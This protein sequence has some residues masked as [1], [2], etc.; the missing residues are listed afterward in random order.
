MSPEA[1]K[2][3]PH[4]EWVTDGIRRSAS[5]SAKRPAWTGTVA[6]LGA[7]VRSAE[8]LIDER[9]T[10]AL[11]AYDAETEE[12]VQKSLVDT[13]NPES[14]EKSARSMRAEHRIRIDEG[15]NARA[16]VS[17]RGLQKLEGTP[18]EVLASMDRRVVESLRLDVPSYS[19]YSGNESRIVVDFDTADGI[20][21]SISGD[22]PSWVRKAAAV[23]IAELDKGVP[24]WGRLRGDPG[25]FF[26][27]GCFVITALALL[28]PYLR[29]LDDPGAFLLSTLYVGVFTSFVALVFHQR[30]LRKRLPGFEILEPGQ[31][32]RG[33]DALLF[34]AALVLQIPLGIF[35]NV[36][37][38]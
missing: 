5:E 9:R 30:V 31:A 6:E 26:S 29:T 24:S 3:D 38:R 2:S 35:V 23:L 17:E 10:A 28:F 15:F 37:T 22:D 21:I 19:L 1:L 32:S 18:E 27:Y 13:Y 33:R 11:I 25:L 8:S 34:V 4:H 14:A 16:K 12:V 36:V 7:F 20:K